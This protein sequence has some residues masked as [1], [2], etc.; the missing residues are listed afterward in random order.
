VTPQEACLSDCFRIE[1]CII[2]AS[3]RGSA[4]GARGH[5]IQRVVGSQAEIDGALA[6]WPS[7]RRSLHRTHVFSPYV[8]VRPENDG[9]GASVRVANLMIKKVSSSLLGL[10]MRLQ[11]VSETRSSSALVKRHCPGRTDDRVK[12]RPS[13]LSGTLKGRAH[14]QA[15]VSSVRAGGHP[16]ASSVA[17]TPEICVWECNGP[18]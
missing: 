12:I 1:A 10:S 6:R 5:P 4:T 2:R 16:L 18:Q 15:K 13:A 9:L 3:W 7:P 8:V 17:K 14:A 11:A